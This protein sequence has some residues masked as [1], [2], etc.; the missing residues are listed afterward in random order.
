MPTSAV[1]PTTVPLLDVGSLPLQP[2]VP[3]PPPALQAVALVELH[4]KV[5]V[6]PS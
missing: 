4:V 5:E 1:G 3:L 6:C 2:S